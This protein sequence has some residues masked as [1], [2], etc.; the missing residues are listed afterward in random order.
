MAGMQGSGWQCLLPFVV[1]AGF[2]ALRRRESI[3]DT[4][5]FDI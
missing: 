1:L 4:M 3:F 5:E 2:G